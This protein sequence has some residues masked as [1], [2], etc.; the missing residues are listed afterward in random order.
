MINALYQQGLLKVFD[1]RLQCYG[2]FRRYKV[3]QLKFKIILLCH[4]TLQV[5]KKQKK[6][7]KT[8][9]KQRKET[10]GIWPTYHKKSDR[11][12]KD[13]VHL[14]PILIFYSKIVLNNFISYL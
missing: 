12:L 10:S 3:Q 11:K 2:G 6:E 14:I 13:K 4:F 1:D 5:L 9:L 8:E 7:K